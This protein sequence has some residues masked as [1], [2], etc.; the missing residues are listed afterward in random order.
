MQYRRLGKSGLKVSEIALG[1]W[2][3]YGA[4]VDKEVASKIIHRA[5]EAGVNFFD[6][7][8]VYARGAAEVVVGEA[9]RDFPRESFVL[10]T[11]AFWPMG[12]GPNDRG[13]SRKHVMEQCHASLRR[14][15]VD[16]IDLFYCHRYDPETP[17]EETLRA[18]D[19]LVSQGKVLYVGVS[20]WTAAQ[21]ADA[22]HLARQM[23]L[24]PLVAD[25]PNYSL[26]NRRIEAEIMPLCAREG[27]GIVPFSPLGQGILTGKYRPGQEAPAGSRGADPKTNSFFNRIATTDRLEKVA[28]LRPI[29]EKNGLTV[30][31]L[32]LAWL[33]GHR[34]VSS[35]LVGATRV[36]QLEENLGASGVPL[37]SE[38]TARIE[39]IFPA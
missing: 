34:E 33:L 7:A 2:L 9:L 29:A 24:D 12:E 6:T 28:A 22:A 25:Q 20:E 17:L 11:K 30:G 26:I 15:G 14:L 4:S 16:Y 21:I 5:Y 35:V 37:S 19:D 23:N 36:E 13:L 32:A 8:N 3:T 27:M 31:Q 18:L 1:S 10:A 39:E 38:D